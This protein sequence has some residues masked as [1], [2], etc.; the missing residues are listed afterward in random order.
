MY[1]IF[2]FFAAMLV[3]ASCAT[4]QV[5]SATSAYPAPLSA[6][7]VKVL[8]PFPS[9]ARLLYVSPQGNDA[10]GK[11]SASNPYATIA[12]ALGKAQRN[13]VIHLMRGTHVVNGTEIQIPSHVS[14][15]GENRDSTILIPGKNI[16]KN[17]PFF[18]AKGINGNLEKEGFQYYKNFTVDGQEYASAAFRAWARKNIL[19]ENIVFK[20]FTNNAIDIS[21]KNI[22]VKKCLFQ[23]ASG[24]ENDG[25]NFSGVLRMMNIDTFAIHDNTIEENTGGGIKSVSSG[26]LNG[27]IY[28]NNIKITGNSQSTRNSSASIEIWDIRKNTH[29]FENTLNAWVSLINQWGDDTS[30][31]ERNNLFF[32]RNT[33][34]ATPGVTDKMSAVEIGLKG[35]DFF[36]NTIDGFRDRAFW[37]EGWGGEKK[38]VRNVRF[39]RNVL[40]NCGEILTIGPHGNS[41]DAIDIFNNTS[42]ACG[43]I[44][45]SPKRGN[46][47]KNIN[48]LNNLIQ[49]VPGAFAFWGE[50][51]QYAN[52][53]LASNLLI[54]VKKGIIGTAKPDI[55][56][57]GQQSFKMVTQLNGLKVLAAKRVVCRTSGKTSTQLPKMLI[58]KGTKTPIAIPFCGAAIDIGAEER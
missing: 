46:T 57:R 48:I 56:V 24:L 12:Y 23:Q 28:R 16:N 42:K 10:Q 32:Y 55:I 39:Y 20:K 17:A 43:G 37:M 36:E 49:D 1:K 45:I 47:Y 58:D 21:G 53:T 13:D 19:F 44:N 9:H 5:N 51:A 11:G 7:T 6:D 33:M 8:K 35:A 22:E 38:G 34:T 31:P 4:A 2:L 3:S 14:I 52:I 15:E 54:N 18:E 40:K 27:R 25:K 50:K 29:I 26:I 41:I 30:V